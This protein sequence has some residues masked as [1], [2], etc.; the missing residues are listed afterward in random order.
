MGF[1][2]FSTK[3][4]LFHHPSVEVVWCLL[5]PKDVTND[6][7]IQKIACAAIYCKPGLK[8][9][10]DLLDHI[11][12]SYHFFSTKYGRGLHFILAGD[13]NELK[14]D[15]ILALS[16]SLVQVVQKPTRIDP[17]TGSQKILDPIIMTLS[18]YY[19]EPQTLAPLD[20]DPDKDGKPADHKIV[21]QKPISKINNK[22]ARITREIQVRPMP[23]SGIDCFKNWLIDQNWKQIF[24][25]VSAHEKAAIFQQILLQ[26]FNEI[27]P[28]KTRKI[29][30]DDAPL[31]SHKI[32]KLVRQRQRIYEK[33][34]KFERWTR[35]KKICDKEIRL[36]KSNFYKNQVA[37]L[38]TKSPKQWYSSFKRLTSYDQY[39]TEPLHVQEISKYSDQQQAEM[40]ADHKAKIANQYQPLKKEDILIP[41]FSPGDIPQ[42]SPNQV[43]LK[44]CQLKTNKG[45]VR[46]DLPAK[47]WKFF[48]AYF[49]E[50]LTDIINTSLWRGEYPNIYK[51]EVQTPVPK[52]C[53]CLRLDTIRNI[54]GLLTPD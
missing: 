40:I 22:N 26:K 4:F 2:F 5:T 15:S 54:S 52:V 50:P 48:G 1:Y 18:T 31:I 53:P 10:S 41:N 25:A 35:L 8:S 37:D 42:F 43:W 46:G 17:I 39:K 9:K 21:I 36:A 29:S 34:R 24:E 12:E 14:L 20:P 7:K 19:Q 44:L 51:F 11:A 23:Q 49:A 3:V 6:S 27:F 16:P 47:I 38:L 32:K 30:S 13:T 33:E 28:L 45:T